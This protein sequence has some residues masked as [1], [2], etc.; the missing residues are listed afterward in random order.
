MVKC[1]FS[2]SSESLAFSLLETSEGWM[3][4]K[5]E[6]DKYEQIKKEEM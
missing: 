5:E 3:I 2:E 1:I 6:M 4:F